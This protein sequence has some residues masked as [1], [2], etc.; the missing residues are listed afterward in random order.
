MTEVQLVQEG[1][2]ALGMS[3]LVVK[4]VK[5]YFHIHTYGALSAFFTG[6]TEGKLLATRCTNPDCAERRLWL[7]P[8]VD[9][10]DC[11]APM[12]WIEAP[13]VG[14]IYTHSTVLYP[15]SGFRL[16]SPCPLISVEIDGVCTK[17]MSYLKQGEPSIGLPVKA[18]FN[19]TQ[20][21]H[22]VLDLAWVPA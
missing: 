18:V 6:L 19:T 1:L 14:R 8:R 7:P 16:S 5:S 22:T 15:G 10:P 2:D 4:N 12:Q 21:T 20:P 13:Q 17:M 9:C 3:P 11:F